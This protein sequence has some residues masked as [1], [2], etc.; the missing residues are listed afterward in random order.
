MVLVP[1]GVFL[2]VFVLVSVVLSA[3]NISE[4]PDEAVVVTIGERNI[5]AEVL[6]RD[7]KRLTLDMGIAD[8]E[9][10]PVAKPL[11]D[12]I[13][14]H[15]LILEYGRK[16]GIHVSEDELDAVI[17]EIQKDYQQNDFQEILL[18]GYVN[19]EDWREGL[20]ERI[21]VKKILK[22]STGSIAPIPLQEIKSYFDAH[23][24]EF[25]HPPMVELRQIVT[26][27]RD[28]AEEIRE[29]LKAGEDMADLAIQYSIA[30][31]AEN[32]GEVGWIGQPDME[33]STEKVIFALPV[34]ETSP[35]V[36]TPYGFHVFEVLRKRPEGLRSLP[37]AMEEIESK[38]LYEKEVLFYKKWLG[39]LRDLFPVWIS[40]EY[41]K[42]M[43]NG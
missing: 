22:R 26:R 1:R 27:T 20:R 23:Q 33:E 3:C 36:E 43:E 6:Q 39:E 21:L 13:V 40:Q 34:G 7:I 2:S 42:N 9:L 24:D 29:R 19:F 17:K 31:E 41:L 15:Y 32:G 18:R 14:E 8:Q 5:T 35:V 37:E 38:L 16:A 12:K 30:P 4:H 25:R 10:E 11:I 28:E